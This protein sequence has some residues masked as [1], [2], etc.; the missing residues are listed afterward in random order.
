MN[1]QVSNPVPVEL[2]LLDKGWS[3]PDLCERLRNQLVGDYLREDG[4]T[5]GV[6][7]LV[8]QG[9]EKGSRHWMIDDKKVGINDLQSALEHYWEG[10]SSDYPGVEAIEIIVIDLT[11]RGT[12][13]DH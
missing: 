12:K 5:C 11:V 13:S 2:K 9:R 6:F 7:L 3:G 1:N 10:V 8:W 4:S